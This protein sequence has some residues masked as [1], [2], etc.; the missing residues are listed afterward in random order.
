MA[1]GDEH[2]KSE[3]P[4]SFERHLQRRH[5]NVLFPRDRQS[6]SAA[7]LVAARQQDTLDIGIAQQR[8]DSL[9]VRIKN[10]PDLV[11]V[12][13]IR[14]IHDELDELTK[15]VL[16]IGGPSRKLLAI[17]RQVRE[18]LFTALQQHLPPDSGAPPDPEHFYPPILLQLARRNGPIPPEDLLPTVLSEDLPTIRSI[19]SK[20]PV[21]NATATE[22]VRIAALAAECGYPPDVLLKKLECL[23][24]PNIAQ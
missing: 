12:K 11:T 15:W 23:L 1:N 10:M 2:P 20:L 3:E 19:A 14:A 17:L 4:A 8:F 6:F 21:S 7:E 13:D 9:I 5:G 18:S 16:T 24:S 22:A